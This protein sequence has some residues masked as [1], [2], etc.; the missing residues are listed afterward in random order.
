MK[1]IGLLNKQKTSKIIIIFNKIMLHKKNKKIKDN[2]NIMIK[3]KINLMKLH[4]KDKF[5]DFND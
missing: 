5:L 3:C 4:N 1:R 2:N